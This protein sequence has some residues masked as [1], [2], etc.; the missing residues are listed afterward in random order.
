MAARDQQRDKREGRRRV[1]QQRREQMALQMMDADHRHVQRETERIGDRSAHQQCAGKPRP[2]GVGN[3]VDVLAR[4]A[5][6]VQHLAQQGQHA[7]D[8]V[9]RGQFGHHAAVF[10]VH[11]DLRVQRVREQA[12]P[13]VIEGQPGFIAGGFDTEDEHE[14]QERPVR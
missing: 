5:G 2:L 4:A 11:G 7:A 9:A 6:V 1:G 3:G 8:M 13:G 12:G 10:A 14:K